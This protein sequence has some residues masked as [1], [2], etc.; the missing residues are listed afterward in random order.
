M[1]TRHELTAFLVAPA[2]AP[3]TSA[4]L[5]GGGSQWEIVIPIAYVAAFALG[6]PLYRLF[7]SRGGS[8]VASS[9]IA[10]VIAGGLTG[11]LLVTAL[12]LGWSVQN[13][14]ANPESTA[15]LIAFGS[16]WGATLGIVAGAVL[17]ALLRVR[18]VPVT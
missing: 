17:W 1:L 8:L 18:S 2:T 16:A 9:L 7:R 14:V 10:G 4:L 5:R 13:F 11:A 3:F 12:L 6:A 15:T